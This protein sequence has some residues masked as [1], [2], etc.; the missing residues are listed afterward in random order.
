MSYR[1]LVGTKYNT[2]EDEEVTLN[3]N[4]QLRVE[5]GGFNLP[6]YDKIIVTYPTTTT[7]VYTYERE[8][9]EVGSIEVTYTDQTKKNLSTV[10]YNVV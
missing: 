8:A 6:L 9:V 5:T 2:H 10:V 7:E 4:G 1:R 3:G